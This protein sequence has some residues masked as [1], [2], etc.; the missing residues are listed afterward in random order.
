MKFVSAFF[1]LSTLLNA[2]NAECASSIEHPIDKATKLA[3]AGFAPN[4]K[5]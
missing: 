1:A 2:V 5:R 4:V 3:F